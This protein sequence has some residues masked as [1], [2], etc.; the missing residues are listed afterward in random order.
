MAYASSIDSTN[1]IK[2]SAAI[3]TQEQYYLN[4]NGLST[5]SPHALLP[6]RQYRRSQSA[7]REVKE[8]RNAIST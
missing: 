7:P 4:L 1:E 2:V 8:T 3:I 5:S 6:L